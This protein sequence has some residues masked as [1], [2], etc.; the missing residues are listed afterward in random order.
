MNPYVEALIEVLKVVAPSLMTVLLGAFFVQR[1][2]VSRANEATLVDFLIK[3]LED[4]RN[5]ALEY[6]NLGGDSKETKQRQSV[7]AQKIKGNLKALTSDVNYHC[8]RYCRKNDSKM[9]NLLINLHDLCTGGEFESS[10]KKVDTQRYIFIVN[11]IND[12]KSELL[13]RKL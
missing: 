9:K 3:E 10:K 5:D 13:R 4:L 11:A 1:F 7:L 12:V 8:E 2:F 6:W